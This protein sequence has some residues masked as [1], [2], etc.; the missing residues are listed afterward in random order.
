MCRQVSRPCRLIVP[1]SLYEMPSQLY[2]LLK[3]YKSSPVPALRR[4][5]T[6]QVVSLLSYFLHLHRACIARAAGG[7]WDVV[8]VVPSSGA[9]PGEHPL[10]SGLRLVP[11]LHA[12]VE[13]LLA[14]GPSPVGHLAASDTAY[15]PVRRLYG[16]RVLLVDD[17]LTSGARAQSAA[18]ALNRGGATVVA[19]VPVGRVI[20]P[21]FNDHARQFWARQRR[22]A[23]DFGSCCIE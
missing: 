2:H 4:D 15:E 3:Q 22:I 5:F 18:S 17:T 9:R 10:V 13:V 19:I 11:T 12:D 21:D 20:R 1:V 16:E 6:V 7:D 23:F 14:R 8:S